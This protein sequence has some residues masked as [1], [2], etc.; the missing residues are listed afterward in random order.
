MVK[1]NS[2]A[3]W[4]LEVGGSVQARPPVPGATT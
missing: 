4:G 1:G 3:R 2:I